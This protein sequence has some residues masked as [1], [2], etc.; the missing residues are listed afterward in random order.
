LVPDDV[1]DEFAVCGPIEEIVPRLLDRC[2]HFMDR[3]RLYAPVQPAAEV[4]L[5]V[6]EH[7]RAIVRAA[8]A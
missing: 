3:V 8:S 6:L 1:V 5:P 7:L 4:W 2:G